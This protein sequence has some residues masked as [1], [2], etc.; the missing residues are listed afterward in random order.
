MLCD[1]LHGGNGGGEVQEGGNNCT[2]ITDLLIIQQKPTQH[3]KS[4]HVQLFATHQAPLQPTR[5]LCPLNSPGKNTGVGS[6][7]LLQGFFPTQGLNPG[8]LHCRQILYCLSHQGNPTIPQFKK[9]R[10]TSLMVNDEHQKE[11]KAGL[12]AEE[13]TKGQPSHGRILSPLPHN[14]MPETFLRTW[15]L[16]YLPVTRK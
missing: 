6:H 15:F 9:K 4:N 1:D 2:H 11:D 12:K 10:S 14:L 7:S 16:L 8:V 5:L 3:C 13:L